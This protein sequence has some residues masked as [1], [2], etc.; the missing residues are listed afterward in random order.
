MGG[1]RK[2]V[3]KT[4]SQAWTPWGPQ[5][6]EKRKDNGGKVRRLAEN[7]LR[8]GKTSAPKMVSPRSSS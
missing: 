6:V 1:E 5:P 7:V 4:R 3:D 2:P 8:L